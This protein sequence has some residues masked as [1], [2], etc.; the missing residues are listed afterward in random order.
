[1]TQQICN[2]PEDECGDA[3]EI[4]LS[5]TIIPVL[6]SPNSN[7]NS[8]NTN[9]VTNTNTEINQPGSNSNNN[10]LQSPP[11]N[12]Y[13]R[14]RIVVDLLN[15]NSNNGINPLPEGQQPQ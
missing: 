15:D 11:A 9:T 7:N 10:D 1:V 3:D 5:T 14:R 8:N 6:T 12:E 2:C 13:K 4:I